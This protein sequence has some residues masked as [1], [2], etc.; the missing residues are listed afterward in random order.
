MLTASAAGI[1]SIIPIPSGLCPEWFDYKPCQVTFDAVSISASWLTWG[2]SLSAGEFAGQ[3][4]LD[5]FWSHSTGGGAGTIPSP[6]NA[7]KSLKPSGKSW[8]PSVSVTVTV[9]GSESLDSFFGPS[10][11]VSASAGAGIWTATGSSNSNASGNGYSIGGGIASPG[12]RVAALGQGS[13]TKPLTVR[14]TRE[15]MLS[16]RAASDATSV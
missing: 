16:V 5:T 6:A 14:R 4:K 2:G 10:D 15:R 13:V 7:A 1:R 8:L 11:E 9:G 3:G 12:L